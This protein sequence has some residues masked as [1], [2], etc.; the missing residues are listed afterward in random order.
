[1]VE[2]ITREPIPSVQTA[3][4]PPKTSQQRLWFTPAGVD[5]VHS[6]YRLAATVISGIVI[7]IATLTLVAYSLIGLWVAHEA[8]QERLANWIVTT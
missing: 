1:M 5:V 8:E 3:S 4:A 2:T 6:D 7:S